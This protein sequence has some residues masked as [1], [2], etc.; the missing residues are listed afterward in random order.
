VGKD[1]IGLRALAGGQNT[2]QGG[3]V[4]PSARKQVGRSVQESHV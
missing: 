3:E 2:E 4:P 1:R